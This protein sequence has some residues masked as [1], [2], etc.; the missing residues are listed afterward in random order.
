MTRPF[1]L[2]L[3]LALTSS[4]FA[5][6]IIGGGFYGPSTGGG[7]P[8]NAV[9]FSLIDTGTGP[10]TS[11]TQYQNP[12]GSNM[13][14]TS[15]QTARSQIMPVSGTIDNLYAYAVTS[16]TSG[17]ETLSLVGQG[18]GTPSCTVTAQVGSCSGSATVGVGDRIAWKAV[19]SSPSASVYYLSSRWHGAA[20]SA[21]LLAGPWST[22]FT[23]TC[24]NTSGGYCFYG[25]G[26]GAAGATAQT[27]D[28]SV[29]S[30]IPASSSGSGTVGTIGPFTCW[31]G[32]TVS[33]GQSLVCVVWHNGAA[34]SLSCTID[35]T[36]N[37]CTDNTSAHYFTVAQ[38]VSNTSADTISMQVYVASGTPNV[39]LSGA[40]SWVPTVTGDYPI[41]A[42][43]VGGM[44][45]SVVKYMGVSGME[46]IAG[47]TTESQSSSIVPV[48]M[49]V[50]NIIY[51]VS[52]APGAAKSR[53]ATLRFGGSGSGTVTC[54]LTT[55]AQCQNTGSQAVT[56][57]ATIDWQFT[58]ASTPAAIT[59]TKISAMTTVP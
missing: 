27:D 44:S 18:S 41:F 11:T 15:S 9:L 49:T 8:L 19:P 21:P 23:N 40:V 36:H 4:A 56:A 28:S 31:V 55:A 59:W 50:K 20:Q 3:F 46:Y 29:S 24:T 42:G 5:Q 10:S 32:G 34:T 33:A 30:L 12:Q 52:T 6:N 14:W 39:S 25:F 43:G 38:P 26:G 22:S 58:P 17:S 16:L 48:N 7:P 2:A 35:N 37:P 13:A 51:Q 1:F 47:Q 53:T 45:T 54:Q 57:G